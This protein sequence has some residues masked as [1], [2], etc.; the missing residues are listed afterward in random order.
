MH[1]KGRIK[2]ICRSMDMG[3]EEKTEVR[4]DCKEFGLSNHKNGKNCYMRQKEYKFQF[5]HVELDAY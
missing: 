2:T 3:Y 4:G 1:F 5:G